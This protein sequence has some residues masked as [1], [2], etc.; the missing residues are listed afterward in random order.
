MPILRINA[1]GRTP[2]L[3]NSPIP[4]WDRLAALDLPDTGPI[5]VML[6]GYKYQ[7][8][9]ARHCPHRHILA[10]HPQ[11]MPWRSPSWPRQLGFG[12]GLADEGLAIAFGW[13]ARGALWQARRRATNSGLALASVISALHRLAP[14]RPVHIVAHSLGLDVA[15]GALHHVPVGSVGRILSLTGASYRSCVQAALDTPAGR[16]A[17]FLN[18]TS[19]ENDPFDFLF[20]QLI[21]PPKRGDRSIGH[22]INAPNAVTV[23]LDC[24][25]TLEHFE[26]LGL[27]IAGSDRRV[28]HWSSYTRPGA[29]QFYKAVLRDP[30]DLTLGR[31]QAGLP[32]APAPRWSRLRLRLRTDGMPFAQQTG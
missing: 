19:R 17:E 23:Q 32:D 31:L 8:G 4:V 16:V 7:P 24:R 14:Q 6:H 21:A 28:C 3:H 18:I 20:E 29:L 25:D 11:D 22:G 9:H 5:V 30:A 26:T 13:N 2:V 12:T 1:F 15:L 27:P 10:L